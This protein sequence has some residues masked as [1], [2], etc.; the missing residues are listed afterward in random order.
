MLAYPQKRTMDS[1][2]GTVCPRHEIA[3]AWQPEPAAPVM[4][5][6]RSKEQAADVK[7]A[8]P[9]EQAPARLEE[10]PECAPDAWQSYMQTMAGQCQSREPRRAG[11][12]TF[13]RRLMAIELA[14]ARRSSPADFLGRLRKKRPGPE[15]RKTGTIAR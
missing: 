15:T 9:F 3:P 7:L 5:R 2:Q 11:V 4:K 13:A 8:R 14:R 10:Q 6:E 1:S 12:T